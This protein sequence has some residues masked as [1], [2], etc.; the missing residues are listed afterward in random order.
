M[1]CTVSKKGIAL[2]K[3]TIDEFKSFSKLF[4]KDILDTIKLEN[5]VKNRSVHGGPAKKEVKRQ[6]SDISKRLN[7]VMKKI[8]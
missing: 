7:Q 2:D 5:A 4:E 8:Y 3:L 6:L 1:Y